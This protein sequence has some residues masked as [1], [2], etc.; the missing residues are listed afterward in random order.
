MA[1]YLIAAV[2]SLSDLN[3]PRFKG[4]DQFQ[5]RINHAGR[6]PRG[7]I[8]FTAKRVGVLGTGCDG[9]SGH[10]GDRATGQTAGP[11]SNAQ[12]T[13]ACRRA[14]AK[15]IPS[16]S[17]QKAGTRGL[18]NALVSSFS[19][20]RIPNFIPKSVLETTVEER[21]REFDR[22][23]DE[24]GFAFWLANY[25]DMF[26]SQEANDVCADYIKRKIRKIVKDP[27]VAEKLVPKG[28]P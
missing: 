9:R 26:F 25:Q 8:D 15:S 20:S 27:E 24:G 10:S 3:V 16:G 6:F 21:E 28:Y 19:G 7:G 5:R 18:S 12:L 22:M 17:T 11:F 23:W 14:M 1:R 4:L 2:G 13:T